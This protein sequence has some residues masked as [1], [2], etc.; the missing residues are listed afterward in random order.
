MHG[1]SLPLIPSIYLHAASCFVPLVSPHSLSLPVQPLPHSRAVLQAEEPSGQSG[2]DVTSAELHLAVPSTPGHP[3]WRGHKTPHGHK[4]PRQSG[5]LSIV[6]TDSES[7]LTTPPLA[8]TKSTSLTAPRI[9]LL[10]PARSLTA[11][12]HP[13]T[14]VVLSLS[15]LSAPAGTATPSPAGA[16]V[17]PALSKNWGGKHNP[18]WTQSDK[19]PVCPAWPSKSCVCCPMPMRK[20]FSLKYHPQCWGQWHQYWTQNKTYFL[21]FKN[22]TIGNSDH[23]TLC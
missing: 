9:S 5:S 16:E 2:G 3:G 6:T 12:L 17:S 19:S 22:M 13:T 14:G 10:F 20:Y 7:S 4:T 18:S 8:L 11:P 21:T 1:I 15:L 23:K